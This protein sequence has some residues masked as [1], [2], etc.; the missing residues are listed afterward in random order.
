VNQAA[1][2]RHINR[3]GDAHLCSSAWPAPYPESRTDVL[4]PVSHP[5]ET[6]VRIPHS[7]NL[8]GIDTA[9]VVSNE[10]AQKVAQVLNFNFDRRRS[11]M[12]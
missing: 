10:Q 5:A 11:R 7:Q 9:T 2:I 4:G 12:A 1:S 6:P 3:H 8:V